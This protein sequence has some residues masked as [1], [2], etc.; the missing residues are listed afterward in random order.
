[1]ERERGGV[2]KN[3]SRRNH[4]PEP[5]GT[6]T[7]GA[8]SRGSRRRTQHQKCQVWK[9]GRE[10]WGWKQEV[11]WT[12]YLPIPTPTEKKV[13]KYL[14]PYIFLMDNFSLKKL[15]WKSQGCW[16]KHQ[17]L[18]A[19]PSRF[20]EEE[21]PRLTLSSPPSHPRGNPVNRF[22]PKTLSIKDK[23]E[24]SN[25]YRGHLQKKGNKTNIILFLTPNGPKNTLQNSSKVL[26]EDKCQVRIPYPAQLSLKGE[27]RIKM[28]SDT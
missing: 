1:M 18:R 15:H 8:F 11:N 25:S 16:N 27:R 3:Q 21:S 23:E 2:R 6:L 20:G 22:C 26:R 9:G 14:F 17:F 12:L 10:K 24:I 5:S 7:G 13:A 28:L 4:H 19:K